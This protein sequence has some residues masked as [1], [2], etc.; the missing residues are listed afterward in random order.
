MEV[1]VRMYDG[2]FKKFLEIFNCMCEIFLLRHLLID[3]IFIET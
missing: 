1:K 3:Q 2:S